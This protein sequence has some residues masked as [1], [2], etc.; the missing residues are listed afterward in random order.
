M[1]TALHFSGGKDSLA[2]VYL[3]RPLWNS[4]TLYHLDA[5]DL[6]PEI[7]EIVLHVAD[8][9]PSFVRIESNADM[10]QMANGLPS[11]L[12]PV[13]HTPTGLVLGMA[14]RPIVDRFSC[15]AGN[16]WRPLHDRM[17]ADE[18]TLVIRGTKRADLARLPHYGGKTDVPYA[19]W[20]PLLEW[21]HEQ[22]FAYL[23]EVGAPI[24]RLYQTRVNSPECATCPA[25]WSEGRA[26]YLSEHH[27]DL[28]TIYRHKLA[29]VAAAV[30]PLM[31]HL[32]TELEDFK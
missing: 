6:L 7:R 32:M 30:A 22:V 4:V 3:L 13:S 10:W 8:M 27:P 11:D 12:V 31:V 17:I 16:L 26:A 21:S 5:G 14:D 20:L 24:P 23:R 19:L 9:V 25:W 2:L 29:D 1:K 18:V 15:C 28:A